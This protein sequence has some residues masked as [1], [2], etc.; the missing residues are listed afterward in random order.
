MMKICDL[1][2]SESMSVRR[3]I[4]L[5]RAKT[6]EGYSGCTFTENEKTYSIKI[7]IEKIQ[8]A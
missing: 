6:F 3:L 2:L 5:L 1:N 7:T 4:N 8:E